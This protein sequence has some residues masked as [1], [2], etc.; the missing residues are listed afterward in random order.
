VLEP[1]YRRFT[2]GS[3]LPDLQAAERLLAE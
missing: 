3:G 2:E 1:V